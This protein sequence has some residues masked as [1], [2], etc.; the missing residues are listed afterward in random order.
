MT[1]TPVKSSL[2][3]I[4]ACTPCE[5]KNW[6]YCSAEGTADLS[7]GSIN[8]EIEVPATATKLEQLCNIN[9]TDLVHFSSNSFSVVCTAERST[10]STHLGP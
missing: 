2:R 5:D 10:D 1:L 6:A 7:F 8:F 9:G 3:S 4:L